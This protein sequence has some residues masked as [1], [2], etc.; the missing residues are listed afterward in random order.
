M[1]INAEPELHQLVTNNFDR[2]LSELEEFFRRNH[3][4]IAQEQSDYYTP[5][6]DRLQAQLDAAK[7]EFEKMSNDAQEHTSELARRKAILNN[8]L[9]RSAKLHLKLRKSAIASKAF[10]SWIRDGTDKILLARTF[11]GIYIKNAR[12]RNF[13]RRWVKKM[14]KKRDTRIETEARQMYEKESRARA[15]EY[16]AE[17]ARL[18]KELADSRNE[19]ETKQKTFIEMQQKLRKA[20]MRGVVNLNLEAMDVFNGAQFMD[21]TQEVEGKTGG[22]HDSENEVEEGDDEFYVEESPNI[23]VIRH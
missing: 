20:F 13:F 6:I 4:T 7:S 3:E 10:H 12:M 15:N 9:A 23:A 16:N 22:T 2:F 1:S 17:I 8:L 14:H 19:L 18:E 21:M 11:E 5:Q